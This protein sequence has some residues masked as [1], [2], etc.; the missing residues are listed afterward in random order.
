LNYEEIVSAADIKNLEINFAPSTH[1]FSG[2]G[3]NFSNLKELWITHQFIKFVER[4]N[5]VGLT[6]LEQL[7]LRGNQIEF[8]PENVF[9]DLPNLELLNLRDNKIKKLPENVFK[10]LRKI[11]QIFL[12]INKIEHLPKNLFVNNLEIEE[13][14]V[15][16]NP[17]KIIDVDFTALKKLR[18]LDLQNQNCINFN[19][20]NEAQS[21]E[22]QQLI[23]QNCRKTTQK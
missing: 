12:S 20:Y 22:T 10:N 5:F 6:Q 9:W 8:L 11:Q 21:Q 1:I 4:S 18:Y 3:E 15:H 23:N 17:L 14:Y 13:I 19:A 16:D 7:Y 2:I